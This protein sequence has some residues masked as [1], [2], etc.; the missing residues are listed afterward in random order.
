MTSRIIFLFLL[1]GLSYSRFAN[2][3][4]ATCT[5]SDVFCGSNT[6]TYPATVGAGNA[7]PGPAYGCL[8]TTP[9]PAWFFLQILDPGPVV[10]TITNHKQDP[11]PPPAPQDNDIDFICWG[12]FT[13]PTGA[14][15]A[16]LTADKIVD[17]SYSGAATEICNIPNGLTGEF[18][19][20]MIT[21]YANSPTDI[22]FSQS[23][24]G[25]P[26]AG[27][28]NCNIVVDCSI[29][30]LT[31]SPTPCDPLSATFT[32]NGTI[33]F[34]NPPTTGSL[35]IKDNTAVPPVQI[36]IN[37]PFTSPLPYSIPGIPCDGLLHDVGGYFTESLNPC[38]FN[39]TY[40][41]PVAPC[42]SGTIAG[43]SILCNSGTS[44]ATITIT[45]GGAPGPYNFTYA[46]NGT[47]QTPVTNYSGPN[48]YILTT[49]TPG[50]YT[51]V[52]MSN[53]TC[54]GLVS[55]SANITL[56]DLPD[57]PVAQNAPFYICGSGIVTLSV[58]EAAGIHVNWYA[59]P[60]GGTSLFTG[61]SYL[62][63]ILN[64]TTTFYAEAVTNT[65]LCASV[66]R[67]AI[68]A[69]V[70]P[71]PVVSN[72]VTSYDICSG[73]TTFI[74]LT[75]NPAG[76]DF[77]WSATCSP[78][79]SVSGFSPAGTGNTINETLTNITAGAGIVTYQ[80][81][82][83]LNQ[84]TGNP[85][86]FQVTVNPL[87]VPVISGPSGLCINS[88]GAF[89]TVIGMTGYTWDVS[90]G[91]IIQ[92]G[93]GT[94]AITSSWN[95]T[96]PHWVTL[97]YTDTHGCTAQNPVSVNIT[98]HPRPV[99]TIAG[100]ASICVSSTGHYTTEPGK[101]D[102]TWSVTSGGTITAGTFTDAV[103]IL[104]NVTG[105]QVVTLNY[106]DANACTAA[107]AA[108]YTVT[109]NP[110]PV[111]MINGPV[112]VCVNSPA[113]Y[114]TTAGMTD[115]TWTISPGGTITSGTGT[116]QIT[117]QWNTEGPQSIGLNYTDLQ[118]CQALT[119]ST[120]AVTINPRPNPVITG[121][122]AACIHTTSN[123][124]TEAGKTAY[125]WDVPTGGTVIS[126]AGTNM[127]VVDWTT[128]GT[129]VVSVNY[130]DAN[131]CIA[132]APALYNVTVNPRP[133]PVIAGP[134][135]MC[136]NTSAAYSTEPGMTG[137]SWTVSAGG[138]ITAGSGTNTV[139]ILW[140][141]T[142]N[143]NITVN[144]LDVN[145]CM[146]LAPTTYAVTVATLP[147]PTISGSN[148]VCTDIPITYSTESGMQSYAWIVS[149][150]GTITGGGLPTDPSIT[151]VWNTSG[152][153]SVG[154]NY[155]IGTGCTAPSPTNYP[156]TVNPSASPSISSAFNQ[157]CANASGTYTTQPGMSAYTWDISPGG[158][159]TA[160]AGTNMITVKWDI[161]GSRFAA[162]NYT[163]TFGCPGVAPVQ[164]GVTVN[165]LPE[166]A[167]TEGP[168]VTC[169]SQ[170]H[171]YH[172]AS[173][174][175]CTF[176]WSVSPASRGTISG[177]QGTNQ[178]TI[179]WQTSGNAVVSVTGT[180][181]IT[182]CTSGSIFNVTVNPITIPA[183]IQCFD[184]VTTSLAKKIILR[185]GSPMLPVQ[186]AFSG[187]RV[188][189]NPSTGFYEFDPFGAIAGTYPITYSYTNNYGCVASTSPVTI[190][191]Q[192][193]SFTCGNLLTDPR[194]GKTYTTGALSGRCWMTENLDYGMALPGPATAPQSDNCVAEK[195]CAPDD[196]NCT[197]KG[198]YYQWDELMAYTAANSAK[199]I[200]PPEWH[201]PSEAE[202]QTL[203]DNLI[204][205][206]GAPHANAVAGGVLKDA[207]LPGGFEAMMSG[208][209]Y[210][211]SR[212]A[213]ETGSLTGTM[214]WTSGASGPTH[215]IARGLNV[216][217]PSVSKYTSNRSNAFPV[218]CIKD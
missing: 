34:T 125:T 11:P 38:T 27:N 188:S 108:T 174:P 10:I 199:G 210:M 120:I 92:T 87:P 95:T 12:P 69:E 181:N 129:H 112:A 41:V 180:K 123:Y 102:Y 116:D 14:C 9:N 159:L 56:V 109:V 110:R 68:I 19:I 82:P 55:G 148:S 46:I 142:G 2:G 179:D 127:I 6:I 86:A 171:I 81:S 21:N 78:L 153:K 151:I 196:A 96:G 132:A 211:N 152:A 17:C 143:Q 124:A 30:S 57:P 126:E 18:Y 43:G 158:T 104:W 65:G 73:Q 214:F 136:L 94:S 52:S 186:S 23:N 100:P 44:S 113:S 139:T 90:P 48:P 146:A 217:T 13:S 101:T 144:Y 167:I 105:S 117:V 79:N 216:F 89:N 7:E 99:V 213:F 88:T 192:N 190:T 49:S 145:G 71:V 212:W 29:L 156:V 168:G 22:S 187:N 80:V 66:T 59:T 111:P 32:L 163:N 184:V 16:G 83:L 161:P 209:K 176:S 75:S 76:A 189:F 4:N 25:Q 51:M 114:S 107:T 97:N 215:A 26:G 169:Q 53:A 149:S 185:G 122:A 170:P 3:Q 178:V 70:R 173:D 137:Y 194:D 205:G 119:P 154:V 20:L 40:Q 45:I 208:M 166:T 50:A 183:F 115:Y 198:G 157:V 155:I 147:V 133:L 134:G 84:C 93:P 39:T 118:L 175:E 193:T 150:G 138:S 202:W 33:E 35:I 36:S 60:S 106:A 77:S 130:A 74:P 164:Y 24:F 128:A 172:T 135:M 160:G 72:S 121:A 131:G 195:Y 203:I 62:T 140:S 58:A 197:I 31:P 54:A 8:S 182:G 28:T 63:G 42:P 91:G 64:T 162:V 141:A 103:D 67:T 61:N 191:V 15:V 204:T 5:N 200:C 206:I 218:R 1:I 201:I 37:P 98:I 177:G 165:P 47:A 207:N 85:L